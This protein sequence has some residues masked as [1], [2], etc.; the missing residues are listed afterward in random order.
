[1]GCRFCLTGTFGLK[2][3][4]RPGEIAGQATA[5]RFRTPEGP[6]IRN[7]VMMG[8]GEP[9]D[10]YDNVVRAIRILT[11]DSG[12]GFSSRRI[13]VSTCGLVPGILPLS[14][15][16]AVN[17]AVSL[18]APDNET[19]SRLMPI[20]RKYP[21]ETLLAA[22][23]DYE[24][25]LR[26]RITFEYILMGGVN[27]SMEQAGKLARLLQGVRCKINLIPFNEF[28]GSEFRRPPDD[29]IDAFRN[30]LI[31][32]RYTAILRASKGADILAACGQLSGRRSG[33]QPKAE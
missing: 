11:D 12:P 2:R 8:M 21:L 9:L 23:R 32:H 6:D 1:M 18:N 28:P 3:N 19:R 22:C 4:L 15:D 26:R 10:N 30:V 16:A 29:R 27:D 17:L 20:N 5:L 33:T 13:T 31:D 14:R 24:M 25:P 7:I